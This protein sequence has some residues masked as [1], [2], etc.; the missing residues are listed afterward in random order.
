ML[1][2]REWRHF[3]ANEEVER[4]KAF[5]I[6]VERLYVFWSKWVLKKIESILK[7]MSDWDTFIW[8][9]HQYSWV[10]CLKLIEPVARVSCE[11]IAV[12][13]LYAAPCGSELWH[14]AELKFWKS[15]W[16]VGSCG[17]CRLSFHFVKVKNLGCLVVLHFNK[18]KILFFLSLHQ[19]HSY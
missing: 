17:K 12:C 9:I 16:K 7:Q 1:K 19:E 8:K 11:S 18:Y 3:E 13:I 4:S 14:P 10:F 5:W 6:R 15:I 2:M